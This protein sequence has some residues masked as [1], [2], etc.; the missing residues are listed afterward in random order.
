MFDLDC[1]WCAAGAAA[2]CAGALVIGKTTSAAAIAIGNTSAKR[3]L[4]L[5][6]ICP[7]IV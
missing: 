4:Y 7:A 1:D 5:L 6:I 2:S 3:D